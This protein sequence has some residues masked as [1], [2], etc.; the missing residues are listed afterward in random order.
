MNAY[1]HM[2]ARVGGVLVLATAA[3]VLMASSAE[4]ASMLRLTATGTSSGWTNTVVITDNSADDSDPTVGRIQYST[5]AYVPGTVPVLPG[6]FVSNLS[7]GTSKPVIGSAASP[8]MHLQG[9]HISSNGGGTL[10]IDHIDTGF[11]HLGNFGMSLGGTSQGGNPAANI[12]YSAYFNSTLIN[13]IGPLGGPTFAGTASGGP[14]VSFPYSL[15]QT[16]TIFHGRAGAG[17]ATTGFSAHLIPEPATLALFGL[18]LIGVGFATNRR[19]N[20]ARG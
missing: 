6:F 15:T 1:R 18:G 4:A 5:P 14:T 20:R 9:A 19:R 12:S 10:V 7:A 16:V 3:G 2:M 11:T 13:T 8:Q 17:T